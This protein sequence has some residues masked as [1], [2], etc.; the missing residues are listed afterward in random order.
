LV[1]VFNDANLN[2]TRTEPMLFQVQT[3]FNLNVFGVYPNPFEE[4]T[5]IVYEISGE[6][7]AEVL[8]IK[9]YNVAGKLINSLKNGE[10]GATGFILENL[11]ST[12]LNSTGA[13][14]VI[15]TGQDEVGAPV[16]NGVYYVRI[17]ATY[18]GKSYEQILKAAKVR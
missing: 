16:A 3:E 7:S 9:I 11:A 15:W 4:Q 18:Q 6:Q 14:I 10:I 13:K 12:D 2:E 17:R 8:E 1:F 5:R